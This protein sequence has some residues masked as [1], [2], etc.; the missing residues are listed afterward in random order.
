MSGTLSGAY[1]FL[2]KIN[3]GYWQNIFLVFVSFLQNKMKGC[4]GKFC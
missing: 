1:S 4:N 2:Q 3:V